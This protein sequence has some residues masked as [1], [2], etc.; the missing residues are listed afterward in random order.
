MIRSPLLPLMIA[1]AVLILYPTHVVGSG[2][3]S[4]A[5]IVEGTFAA[6]EKIYPFS[7]QPQLAQY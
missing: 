2:F 1:R 4:P 7:L 3:H 5:K 6:A